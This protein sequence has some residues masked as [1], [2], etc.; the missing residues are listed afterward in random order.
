MAGII[1]TLKDAGK[2]AG[3]EFMR[4]ARMVGRDLGLNKGEES[5]IPK[6]RVIRSEDKKNFAGT[7]TQGNLRMGSIK[8]EKEEGY[9]KGGMTAS[10]RGD[11]IAQRGKT[12]GTI[13]ACGG[14]YMK[15]K[16]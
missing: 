16:K 1:D 5:Y 15:G 6:E 7:D 2:V 11:G 9:K 3:N 4:G 13:I 10:K 8:T 14:G 12:R